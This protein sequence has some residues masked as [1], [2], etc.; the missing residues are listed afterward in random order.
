MS[1]STARRILEFRYDLY[2][3]A[4]DALL[5]RCGAN[6]LL[7]FH[8]QALGCRRAADAVELAEEHVE[9]G[10]AKASPE[11]LGAP[12]GDCADCARRTCLLPDE[13][14]QARADA[15]RTSQRRRRDTSA[16]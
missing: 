16:A 14:D 2:S 8:A 5:G 9:H 3:R 15:A 7:R 12:V 10:F 13:I 6:E 11:H 4:W 1:D